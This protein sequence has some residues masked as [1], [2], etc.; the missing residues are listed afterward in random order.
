MFALAPPAP[1]KSALVQIF[2]ER[3]TQILPAFDCEPLKSF[4]LQEMAKVKCC[5]GQIQSQSLRKVIEWLEITR[6]TA[7]G[8][9]DYD[10]R[11]SMT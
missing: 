3:S 6:K 9:Y 8:I 4:K 11:K 1:F 2:F 5:L 7:R 10:L